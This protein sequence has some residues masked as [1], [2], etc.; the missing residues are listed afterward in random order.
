MSTLHQATPRL[1][2]EDGQLGLHGVPHQ[3]VVYKIIAVDK[4]IAE[5]RDAP[6]FAQSGDRIRVVA[7]KP[8][9]RFADDLEVTLDGLP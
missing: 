1:R 7:G 9:H 8:P 3:L 2:R 5:H 6:V 4:Y